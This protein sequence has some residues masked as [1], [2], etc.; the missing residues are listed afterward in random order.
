M[1]KGAV[2]IFLKCLEI[3]SPVTAREAFSRCTSAAQLPTCIQT[4]ISEWDNRETGKSP[5]PT[6][7]DHHQYHGHPNRASDGNRHGDA[8]VARYSPDQ[9][10]WQLA[11]A[12]P[13]HDPSDVGKWGDTFRSDTHYYI[14]L[15]QG[16]P[17]S[18]N[19]DCL[20]TLSNNGN[21]CFFLIYSRLGGLPHPGGCR[22]GHIDPEMHDLQGCKEPCLGLN[23]TVLKIGPAGVTCYIT[24][25]KRLRPKQTYHSNAT[26]N[27]VCSL[28]N[29]RSNSQSLR[30]SS[31]T[32]VRQN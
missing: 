12:K 29:T 32:S 20:K 6:I 28:P 27:A 11:E 26:L 2:L 8:A 10:L 7:P 5:L 14:T 13:S 17:P 16:C 18:N 1:H 3:H 22:P 21:E 31:S 30:W 4:P 9:G 23:M 25:A 19:K 24:S 15:N